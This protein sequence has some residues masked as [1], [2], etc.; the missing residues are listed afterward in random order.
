MKEYIERESTLGEF[1]KVCNLCKSLVERPMCGECS[2]ADTVRK[3]KNIPAADVVEVVRCKDCKWL[4]RCEMV[5][6]LLSNNYEPPVYVEENDYCS[7]GVQK[8][9]A[10]K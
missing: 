2:I 7:K 1:D 9:G 6:Y 8:G 4:V 3:V 5:C 10:D